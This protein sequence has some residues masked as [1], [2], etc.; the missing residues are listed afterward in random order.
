MASKRGKTYFSYLV[1]LVCVVLLFIVLNVLMKAGVINTYWA[2]VIMLIMINIILA[3][4]LNLTTG[5]LGQIALGHAGFMSVG[6][7][8]AAI[9]SMKIAESAKLVENGA[10]TAAGFGTFLASLVVAGVVAAIFG[11]IVGIPALRLKGDY[12][13]I[14]T[15]GFGEIIRVI[16]E[17]V[18]FTGGAQGLSG[19]P[20]LSNFNTVYWVTALTIAVLFAFGRSRHGRAIIA[21]RE[22][23]IASEASGIPNTYYKVLAFT[24]SAFFAGVAGAI[25]AQQMQVLG[26]KTFNFMRSIDI[27]V[28]VVLGGLGSL[29]GSII[30]AVGLTVLPEAL[31]GFSEYRMLIYSVALIVVMIFK[32]S[33][34][35][36]TREFSM[37]ALLRWLRHP[38]FKRKKAAAERGSGK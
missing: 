33:G 8:A 4:S 22:D 34:L 31:R 30:A 10:P 23:D 26:A 1:N 37:S 2:G 16:I 12:L 13:A 3:T 25:Y 35:L 24:I 21:I 6:A 18:E 27:L 36:G 9:F 29:T 28:I 38:Q 15:L 20:K 14:I 32:P 7:Y 17:N 19:I 11:L 5:V